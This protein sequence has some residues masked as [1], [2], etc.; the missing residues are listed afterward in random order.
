ML[1]REQKK[2]I[3]GLRFR[4]G[5]ALGWT[6]LL[7]I[8]LDVI[9]RLVFSQPNLLLRNEGLSAQATDYLF[10]QIK[11]DP[12]SIKIAWLGASVMQGLKNVHQERT[13][14]V[15]VSRRL[16]EQ[17]YDVGGYNLAM[18]GNNMGD[19][20]SFLVEAVDRGAN[21]A[22]VALHYKGFTK[23][24]KLGSLI[25]YK[26]HAYYARNHPDFDELNKKQFRIKRSQWTEIYLD[27]S[28]A[29]SWALYRYRGMMFT[30]ASR[31]DKTAMEFFS[32]H[33]KRLFGLGA[34]QLLAAADLSYE[35]RNQ[36]NLWQGLPKHLM[37]TNQRL[38]KNTE[39]NENRPH[40][41]ILDK[42]CQYAK[43][44]NV[45]LLFFFA[46]INRA[47]IEKLP[48]FDWE[49]FKRYKIRAAT[50]ILKNGQMIEDLSNKIDTRY[51]TDFDHLNTNGHDQMADVIEPYLRE[52]I[53]RLQEK[54]P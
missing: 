17:G 16:G 52:A 31:S 21:V 1:D 23:N 38:F 36:D 44:Q 25:R 46:P 2:E 24:N 54:S 9:V 45:V 14:P 43:E 15:T 20:F 4:L 35:A 19:F 42:M 12:S 49:K 11:H 7:F 18:A 26:E 50:H 10:N 28:L 27:R 39:I 51:F 48:S 30:L 29:K 3:T 6:V 53:A 22:P 40:W 33:Y 5:Y 34:Q 13:Y 8:V 41:V 37:N 47:A 32:Y